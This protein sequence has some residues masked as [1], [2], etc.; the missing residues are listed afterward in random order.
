M[1]LVLKVAYDGR[2]FFGS[3]RQSQR[4][5]VQGSLE[6]ALAQV[7]GHQVTLDSAGRTDQGVHATGQ[8]VAFSTDK[9]VDAGRLCRSLNSLLGDPVRVVE[10]VVL[11][12]D[13][14]FHPRYSATARTY[15]YFILDNCGPREE[16]LWQG[17][18]WCLPHALELERATQAAALFLGEMDFSTFS[19]KNEKETGVRRVLD[20]GVQAETAS[21]L[22]CPD[23]G[24]RLIRL[25]ITANGFLRRMVRL[26]TAGVVEVGIGK[27]D[28]AD[29]RLRLERHDPRLAPHPAPPDG[30]YL[31]HIAYN[32]DPFASA[33]GN[34]RHARDKIRWQHRVKP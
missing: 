21:A 6:A 3:Q 11:E 31:E 33:R 12:P 8:V 13:N 23:P 26:V 34:P 32:P 20:I 14:P 22:L 9:T 4:K 10:A 28:L 27:R 17:R 30:L 1:K 29:L 16:C 24:P 7:L 25:T 18:V 5:T 19:Y 2:A 15:S